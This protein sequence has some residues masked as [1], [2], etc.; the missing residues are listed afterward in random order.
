MAKL[1]SLTTQE[2]HLL[3]CILTNH[4]NVKGEVREHLGLWKRRDDDKTVLVFKDKPNRKI[5]GSILTNLI[6]HNLIELHLPEEDRHLFVGIWGV[7]TKE[8]KNHPQCNEIQAQA[9]LS[10]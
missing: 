7:N 5:K 2:I 3:G 4:I 6:K 8:L 9:A 10:T 1:T